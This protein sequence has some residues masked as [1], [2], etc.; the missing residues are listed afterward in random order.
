MKA[1]LK[2]LLL[3]GLIVPA[4][5][6]DEPVGVQNPPSAKPVTRAAEVVPEVKQALFAAKIL[7]CAEEGPE[8]VDNGV[9]LLSN[10]RIEAIGRRGTL[11]VPEGYVVHDLGDDWLMP[12]MIDLHSHIAGSFDI[13]DTV[14][15]TNPGVRASTAVVPRNAN[16]TRA[17]AAGVTSILFIPGSGSNIG[18]QG[19]LLKTGLHDYESMEIRNPGSMKLAQSGNPER[20]AWGVARS[21]MNYHT[22]ETLKRGVAYA[23]SWQ[24]FEEGTGPEP[25]I[26]LQ[27]EIFRWLVP[28]MSQISAHTQVYQ[29]VAESLAMLVEEMNLPLFIDHGTIGAW[30]LGPEIKRLG[31]AAQLGPRNVD[32]P[33][34]GFMG[35]SQNIQ[36]EGWRGTAVGYQDAGVTEIGFNTDAPVMP[37][38]ELQLQATVAVRHGFRDDAMQAV[39]GLTIIPARIANISHETGSLEVGKH[40]DILQITGH[41]AD[42]RSAVERVWIEGH[43]VYDAEEKREY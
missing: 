19:V 40:A 32:A 35:W 6:G 20:F 14:Y 37:Q 8:V 24:A 33:S 43:L 41:P 42:P 25:D 11:E 4:A 18:G 28:H 26:D 12:G 13:N 1:P 17:V 5:M 36:Y 23:Q 16:L 10:G 34:R 3:A 38:E 39:R 29:V 22:R 30:K 15:L 27:F 9:I 31:V 21:F 7:T 2:G